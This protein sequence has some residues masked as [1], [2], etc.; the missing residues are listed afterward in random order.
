MTEI[1]PNQ[2]KVSGQPSSWNGNL[3]TNDNQTN[4]RTESNQSGSDEFKPAQKSPVS[5]SVQNPNKEEL[6]KT[7]QVLINKI[8][9][10]ERKNEK[11][12]L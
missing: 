7:P 3:S 2:P 6:E 4:G 9:E 8:E 5:P 12:R 10:E 1:R 11:R